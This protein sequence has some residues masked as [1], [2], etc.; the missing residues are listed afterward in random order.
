MNGAA[1]FQ[2]QLFES[3]HPDTFFGMYQFWVQKPNSP[4]S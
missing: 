2:W 4:A 3:E 1:A